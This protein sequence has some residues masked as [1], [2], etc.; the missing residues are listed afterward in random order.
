[1]HACAERAVE[2]DTQDKTVKLV[3]LNSP[4]NLNAM[5]VELGDAFREAMVGL[6]TLPPSELRAVVLTGEGRAFSAGGD[7][8]FLE[9]R[10]VASPTSNA[11]T[12]RAFYER[13]L[14]VR[15]VPAESSTSAEAFACRMA[16]LRSTSCSAWV[17]S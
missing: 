3:T 17:Y 9:D 2:A 10:R 12:M 11:L 16:Q 5:T 4:K 15:S 14:S 8:T 7:L 6:S 1:M 13:F